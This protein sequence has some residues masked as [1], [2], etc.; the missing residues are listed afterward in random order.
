MEVYALDKAEFAPKLDEAYSSMMAPAD[1]NKAARVPMVAL[2]TGFAEGI[3]ATSLDPAQLEKMIGKD[4]EMDQTAFATFGGEGRQAA[5]KTGR[6]G[7]EPQ[8]LRGG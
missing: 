5:S 6:F 3:G 7:Q 8:L 4:V 1:S 2:Y